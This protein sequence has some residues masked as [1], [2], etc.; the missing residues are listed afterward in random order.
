MPSR[1]TDPNEEEELRLKI[2]AGIT[3]RLKALDYQKLR[4]AL[5]D[6]EELLERRPPWLTT[7]PN[8]EEEEG[9]KRDKHVRFVPREKIPVIIL[10]N[11]YNN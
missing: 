11:N 3:S 8:W 5:G 4:S 7:N 9:I 1:N 6:F 2:V 10:K